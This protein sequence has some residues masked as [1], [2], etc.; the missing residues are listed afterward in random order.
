MPPIRY[1]AHVYPSGGVFVAQQ[2]QPAVIQNLPPVTAW[3]LPVNSSSS[4]NWTAVDATANGGTSTLDS[5]TAQD[6]LFGI[7]ITVNQSLDGE[8][9]FYDNLGVFA[10]K[11]DVKT[12]LQTLT[13]EGLV[14]SSGKYSMV[15]ALHDTNTRSLASG[16]YMARVITFS[17]V[18]VNGVQQRV[19]MQN[20]LYKVGYKNTNK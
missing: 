4:G 5:K 10:G 15:I 19:M 14:S 13:S 2:S 8:F 11:V 17:E 1:S 9:I 6:G 20:K 18:P 7:L 16:V 12:D 3:V